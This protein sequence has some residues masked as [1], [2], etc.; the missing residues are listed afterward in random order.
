MAFTSGQAIFATG[1]D[2]TESKSAA[3]ALIALGLTATAAELNTLDGITASVAELNILDGVTASTAE[4]NY[5][6]GVAS[7]IQTQLDAKSSLTGTE[8]LTNKR[9]TARV[10]TTASSATP[11]PLA[12]S[13]DIYT[14]T[15]LAAAA[16]LQTPSGTPTDGQSLMVRI[17]D[18]GT[19]R[20]L[21]YAAAYRAIGVSLPSTTVISKTLYLGMIYNSADSKWDVLGVAQEA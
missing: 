4:L 17:K 7:A 9:L 11:T 8:T 2:T 21:T 18:N 1:G 20:A 19:A 16:E 13:H 6:D 14:V 15:A 10:G 3:D 5:V 12:D